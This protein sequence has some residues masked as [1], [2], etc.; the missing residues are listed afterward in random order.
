[1]LRTGPNCNLIPR[2][3]PG[4]AGSYPLPIDWLG[5][6][7]IAPAVQPI[8]YQHKLR[9]SLIV[10][11]LL[12]AVAV[13][14]MAS[15]GSDLERFIGKQV[16][17]VDIVVEGAP[18]SNTAEMRDFISVRASQAFST[19]Q[20]HDSLYSLFR[21]GLVS[22][23]RVEA[24]P[25]GAD[26]VT[27]RFIVRPRAR[28]DNIV[29]EGNTAFSSTQLRSQLN[30]L[31]IGQR[32]TPGLVARGSSDLQA[33][34]AIHGYYKA[35]IAP[36]VRL[37]AAGGHATVVYII[38][39][40]MPAKVSKEAVVVKG[41]TIDLG[42]IKHAIVEGKP[43]ADTDLQDELD[44]IKQAYLERNYL[45]VQVTDTIE[46]NV[47]ENGVAL[48]IT[49]NSGP[50]VNV[51]VQ[52]LDLTE[53]QKK[54]ILPFY[55]R[56]G[57]DDFS[58]E[59]GR[60]RLIDFAQRQGYF[61]AQ[62][63]RP[64]G[65]EAPAKE[66][67]LE[68]VVDAGRRY[69]L[70]GIEITGEDAVPQRDLLIQ[71]KSKQATMVS[72]SSPRRGL[73][74]SD[75]LRQDAGT[76]QKRLHDLGYRKAEV[77]VLR[78][79][80][81]NGEG[82]MVTFDVTQGPRTY[83]SDVAVR[84]NMMVTGDT[85]LSRVTIKPGDPMVQDA[86]NKSAD[87]MLSA[88]TVQGYANAEIASDL[89]EVGSAD[90]QDRV[91]VIYGVNEGH[92]VRIQHVSTNGVTGR[93]KD[94]VEQNFYLFKPGDWLRSDKVLNTERALYDT[95]AFSSVAIHSDPASAAKQGVEDCDV[96]VDMAQA[97]RW[98]LIYSLGY[99]TKGGDP[100]LPDIGVLHGAEGLIQLTDTDM[101]NKLDTGSVQAR[102]A[103]DEVLG[104]ISFE[105]PRPFG[106]TWPLVVSIFA[107]RRA[108]PSFSS[109]RYTASI[110]TE[111]RL[112]SNSILYFGYYFE[113]ITV[114]DLQLS[115][116]LEIERDSAPVR[117]GRIGPSYVRDTRDSIFEPNKGTLTSGSFSVASVAFGGNAQFVKML[118]EHDRYY[119]VPHLRD[120]VYSVSGRLGL[121]SAFGGESTLP[122]SERFFAG[123]PGDLRGFGF[124]QAGP[125]DPVTGVPLGG[126][127]LI[128]V[129]NELR[130]PIWNF[131]GGAI[132]SD[133]GNVYSRVA[134]IDLGD[135]TETLGFGIRLK[136]PI[137]P[138][139]FDLGFLV[140]NK[141][142]GQHLYRF[143]ASF[144]QT[145]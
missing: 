49:I 8:I 25:A 29:F 86:I 69:R 26:G 42:A 132:F 124:E 10:A 97:K 118:V 9:R 116:I 134:N 109:N 63:K 19:V 145:F 40:G 75:M 62:V 31:D 71:L 127:A 129:R 110:Q 39:S 112:S 23:A 43:F 34:Y 94:R 52:G 1:V 58:L 11:G 137:G 87:R 122:I 32:L 50:L 36:D 90:G 130:F 113:R 14:A 117:L 18:N 144:G 135:L 96:T 128:V 38:E 3:K 121:A 91:R 106:L 140:A 84:G 53:Q 68:Y 35:T 119:K 61:F 13:N 72:F 54:Q 92:R 65:A 24:E 126:N 131:L 107:Q 143:D 81:P 2:K 57:V 64:Q 133:T 88:Y 7:R 20:I 99:Q 55:S 41:E 44:H 138:L 70:T 104:E 47:A 28:I 141:P 5:R 77:E 105:D 100:T 120:V 115:S 82:L 74:S 123:G 93:E 78:G 114:F 66:L 33:F 108:Q 16:T 27:V 125:L 30:Q 37:D 85:L 60:R 46:P 15:G 6:P 59:E 67:R 95:N 48:T 89:I 76:I 102:V 136:T 17:A 22:A 21:S 4:L 142:A 111:R 103:Q 45:A 83:V 80:S 12:V 79:V 56:G 98:L 101:F 139:R 73:T 51:A